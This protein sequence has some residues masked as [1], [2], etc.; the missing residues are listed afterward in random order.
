MNRTVVQ[1]E[2]PRSGDTRTRPGFGYPPKYQ[3]S[4]LRA[5]RVG[6]SRVAGIVPRKSRLCRPLTTWWL[7]PFWVHQNGSGRVQVA[8]GPLGDGLWPEKPLVASA[9][10]RSSRCLAVMTW[11]AIHSRA[12]RESSSR[13]DEKPRALSTVPPAGKGGRSLE[14]NR[15]NHAISHTQIL[16]EARQADPRR[17]QPRRPQDSRRFSR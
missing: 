16:L 8:S 9:A 10:I 14:I 12:F 1:R 7:V 13:R 15:R 3:S 4:P 2:R 5:T 17:D 6:E 11:Q